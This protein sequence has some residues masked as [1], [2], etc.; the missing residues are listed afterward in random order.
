MNFLNVC[1]M[2]LGKVVLVLCAL[3]ASLPRASAQT[4]HSDKKAHPNSPVFKNYQ[5][6]TTAPL[7]EQSD[8]TYQM[9]QGF[10]LLQ[11][12]NAGNPVSQ[13]EL[14]IRYLT[15][16]GFKADTQKA[17]YWTKRASDQNH[18]LARY[19]L[20][21]F[22]FNGW[23]VEWN[24]FDA[25]RDFRFVAERKIPEA[26]YVLAQFLTENLVV[27]RNW[28][29]AYRWVK[30][31][32]DSGY[33]PAKEALKELEKRGY[34]G[35]TVRSSHQATEHS[36]ASSGTLQLTFLNFSQD[37]TAAPSDS[38]LLDD[39][40]KAALLARNREVEKMFGA[41]TVNA[42]RFELDSLAVAQ[43]KNA[44]E[45][46]SPEALTLLARCYHKGISVPKDPLLAAMTYIRAIRFDSP[47]GG[48]LLFELVHEKEFF[49][50]L[51]QRA[52]RNDG[53]AM[54]VW[55]CLVALGFDRQLTDA[56]ALQMLERAAA[57][58]HVQSMVELGL[59]YYAGR[60]VKRSVSTAEQ[61]WRQAA[62]AGS[63]EARVRLAILNIREK[64]NEHRAAVAVL[65]EAAREGSVLAEFALAYCYE[66]GTGVAV[67][68]GEAARLYRSSG[69]RGSQDA[70][71]A[72]LRMH[73]AIRPR[74]EEFRIPD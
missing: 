50:I 7:L 64:K 11:E 16:R 24:P 43:L 62:A 42:E 55:A 44:A 18:L 23:G 70:Y 33:G 39:A 17:A 48:R 40:L 56:Q 61:L 30:L 67:D 36:L 51:R 20:A 9:W 25:Y 31:A 72:L 37:T 59:C 15:G 73:D 63:D 13:F 8:V 35:D 38:V 45:A 53:D 28:N 68:K 69:Q 41:A 52:G 32:A 58:R 10:R 4:E 65:Q 66:T 34:G 47:R 5:P 49:D 14:S 27:P 46:G 21:I 26:Q 6:P 60:W 1:P 71:R 54:Y 12:A 29:E 19:N 2:V 22:E 3:L 74:G 57:S